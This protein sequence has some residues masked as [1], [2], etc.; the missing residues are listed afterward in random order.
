M[1]KVIAVSVSIPRLVDIGGRPMSTSIVRDPHEGALF[2]DR[3]GPV[4][5]RTAVHTEPVLATIAE[6][7]DFWTRQLGVAREAWPPCFWGENLTLSGL[8]EHTLRVGDRL[9]I[10][11]S[12]VFEVTSPRIPCIKL[13]WR[14]GQPESFLRTLVDSGLTG[15]Y[16]RVL[17]PGEICADDS[18]TLDSPHPDNISVAALSRLLHDDSID[19]EQ[20]RRTLATP[21]LGDQASHMLRHRL[22][23]LT[24]GARCKQGRWPGWRPFVVSEIADEA[25]GVR[26]FTLQPKDGGALAQYRAGQFLAVRLQT[27]A[28]RTITRTWSLSDYDENGTA[29]RLTILRAPQ[30]QASS[31]LHDLTKVGD[32]LDVRSPGGVFTLDR[33]SVFRVVL[34]SAGIGV[35]PLLSMLKAHAA[36]ENAPPLLWIHTTRHGGTHALRTEADEIVR[37]NPQFRSH[38]VYTAPRPHDRVGIDYDSAGRPTPEQISELLGANYICRPF[39]REVELPTQAGLFYICGPE[40]FERRVRG[41]LMEL[42]VGPSAIHSEGFGRALSDRVSVVSCSEVRFRRAQIKASWDSNDG[43]SLLELAEQH[44]LTPASSC[45]TGTCLTC[46]TALIAGRVSYSPQ[47]TCEPAAGRVLIC[48][49]RP[50]SSVLELDL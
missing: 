27:S 11:A 18:V 14:L 48:C 28:G 6:N 36:R 46:E 22:T 17:H 4:G 50:A 34:I 35:T 44:G 40:G 5:N 2:F 38:V 26:S 13:S 23:H 29:Y 49:A 16:L 41:T 32:L 31:H 1:A 20:L 10:G 45:R 30:G 21:G 42:G 39:G 37:D 7:Y 3:G 25:A 43:S 8:S 33:S 12:A 15:F 47:P 24:D 9:A 19:V